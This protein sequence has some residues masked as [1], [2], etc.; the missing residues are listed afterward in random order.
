MLQ[1]LKDKIL[2]IFLETFEFFLIFGMGAGFG[3][4]AYS[5][6]PKISFFAMGFLYGT[7][8]IFAVCPLFDSDK[9]TFKPLI[10]AVA[11]A[12]LSVG[13][14][15]VLGRSVVNIFYASIGVL[16]LGYAAPLWV[17]YT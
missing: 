1:K 16:I 17:K 15:A 5:I 6:E 11:G 3:I 13:W 10:C 4:G 12:F 14:G 8:L 7:F 9:W 2:D